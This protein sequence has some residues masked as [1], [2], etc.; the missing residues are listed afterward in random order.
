MKAELEGLGKLGLL[1]L[2]WKSVT[3]DLLHVDSEP[4]AFQFHR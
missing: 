3:D 2:K 1:A 4:Q